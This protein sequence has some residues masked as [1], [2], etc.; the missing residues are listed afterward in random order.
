MSRVWRV[1]AEEIGLWLGGGWSAFDCLDGEQV[2][3]GRENDRG[4]AAIDGDK[5]WAFGEGFSGGQVG[6]GSEGG[7]GVAD[8]QQEVA[9]AEGPEVLAVVVHAPRGAG[10]DMA[11]GDFEED[12]VD[13]AVLIV[14]GVVRAGA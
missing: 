14:L 1:G 6:H 5:K 11:G 7:E 3:V 8:A 2:G 9:V 10:E 13:V 12:G 4:D